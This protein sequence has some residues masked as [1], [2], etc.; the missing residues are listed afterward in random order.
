MNTREASALAPLLMKYDVC[1][2]RYTSYPTALQ[3]SEQFT[4]QDYL[5]QVQAS[6]QH[7][8]PKP[9]SLY[10]H[11]PFC[12][13]LCYYC[14]CNKIITHK[15]S[16]VEEYL[17]YLYRE[18][19]MQGRHFADD[20][21]VQQIHFGGGTPTYLKPSQLREILEVVAQAFHLG[22][23]DSL[24]IGIEIDPRSVTAQ[25]VTELVE[26]GFNRVS[27]GVQDFDSD[28]QA[29]INRVQSKQQV[30]AVV[31]HAR[32][33]GVKS[34]SLDIIY[35]L[36]LQ[37][38]SGFVRTL[39]QVIDLRPD[40]I[41][42]YNYAHMPDR[43]PSQRLISSDAIPSRDE[44]MSIFTQSIERL[45]S[46][47][48][49][50]IGMDHFALPEDSLA[51]A[52]KNGGLQ[53]NFQGY[54]THAECDVVGL[55]LSAIS[56][57]NDSYS[58]NFGELS[59]YKTR[60]DSAELPIAKGLTLTE[61][62]NIRADV[63]HAIMC[64]GEVDFSALGSQHNI[65]FQPH[66]QDELARLSELEKDGLVLETDSG[67]SVTETG[68]LFLRNIAMEFDA[69]LNQN[70]IHESHKPRYSRTL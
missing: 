33:A 56:R 37:T 55:G 25:S 70:T 62:D 26:T 13:Q 68:R 31:K 12:R 1:G 8:L 28:V 16:M 42:L 43:I 6:N 22:L 29:A 52:M 50:Y 3:F 57:V 24:E 30:E 53:R 19:E 54:S 7:P 35:G 63:I 38:K 2:P 65:F 18:I 27:V 46:A 47:G 32:Q 58:Q 36:P 59:R 49:V 21:L 5:Q 9:L 69:Y 44:K 23:P 61:E 34:V 39:D 40:R 4:E 45:T 41:A 60:I 10:L 48:Y 20:R 66:F 15:T 67:F 17:E 51:K 64:K 14:G 11:I